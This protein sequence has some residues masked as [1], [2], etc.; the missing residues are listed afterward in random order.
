[1]MLTFLLLLAGAPLLLCSTQYIVLG[2]L[3]VQQQTPFSYSPYD[4][5]MPCALGVNVERYDVGTPFFFKIS[6]KDDN[7][8]HGTLYVGS[9]PVRIAEGQTLSLSTPISHYFYDSSSK[10]YQFYVYKDDWYKYLYI[11]PPPP[12]NYKIRS[13]ITVLNTNSAV[14]Y[15]LGNIY[16]FSSSTYTPTEKGLFGLLC[17]DTN[18]FPKEDHYYFKTV[19]TGGSF[20]DG[21]MLYGASNTKYSIGQEITFDHYAISNYTSTNRDVH[22]F[23]I[24]RVRER[25]LYVAAPPPAYK[26]YKSQYK[27]TVS[28]TYRTY[29]QQYKVMGELPQYSNETFSPSKEGIYNTYYIKMENFAKENEIYFQPGIN[30]GEFE[31]EYMFYLSSD[32]LYSK[33]ALISL[34]KTVKRDLAGTTFTISKP[35]H[36]YLYVAPPPA[37][38]YY[39]NSIV[40]ISN[41]KKSNSNKVAIGVGVGVACA[42]IIAVIIII[43]VVKNKNGSV[44][45]TEIDTKNEPIHLGAT[46]Y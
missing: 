21:K 20:A 43:V 16:K 27:V 32:T 34:T 42:V 29:E 45:S 23:F 40:S 5:Q 12:S 6:I 24:P 13:K 36:K 31:N 3:P 7:F 14:Y 11:A 41:E 46:H 22:T 26:Y 8:A 19:M 17:L 2:D 37:L 15:V 9:S 44:E 4:Y 18:D 10:S 1:M 25:Y 33:G 28:N 30:I 35:S 39:S 38:K